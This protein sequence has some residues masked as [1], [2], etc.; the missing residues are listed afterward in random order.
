MKAI[1]EEDL[2]AMDRED[3]SDEVWAEFVR[4]LPEMMAESEDRGRWW[5]LKGVLK[6]LLSSKLR[7]VKQSKT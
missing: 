3:A 1:K 6:D 5:G 4:K 2:Y 7:G